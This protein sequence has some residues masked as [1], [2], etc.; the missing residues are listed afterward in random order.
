MPVLESRQ[1][2]RAG[3]LLRDRLREDP[4]VAVDL[5]VLERFDA[6]LK[7]VHLDR[8]D[9]RGCAPATGESID[10]PP[11]EDEY[12]YVVRQI[13]IST[14]DLLRGLGHRQRTVLSPR[15]ASTARR[16]PCARLG[17]GSV[18][19]TNAAGTS[20]TITRQTP[21]CRHRRDQPELIVAASPWPRPEPVP[22]STS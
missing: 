17:N 8:L 4:R 15:S 10:D 16:S 5:D 14:R 7:L 22:A 12:E 19:A 21:G 2:V 20:R 9:Q 1:S 3:G 13:M 18:S 6:R 11:A